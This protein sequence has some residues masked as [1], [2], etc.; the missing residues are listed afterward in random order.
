MKCF[1]NPSRHKHKRCGQVNGMRVE[2]ERNK[3]PSISLIGI[4]IVMIC[5]LAYLFVSNYKPKYEQEPFDSIIYSSERYYESAIAGWHFIDVGSFSIETPSDYRFFF[6]RGVH[7]G[8]VGGFTNST[9]TISFVHGAYYFDACDGI[10]VGEIIGTCDTLKIFKSGT[11]NLIIAQTDLYISAYSK[12]SNEQ[13]DVF[14]AWANTNMNK[15]CLF[16]IYS[17]IKFIE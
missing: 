5:V 6:E 9:D 4:P 3:T 15:D 17:T 8:K 11:R 14:K 16:K 10:V 12:N 7:G 1:E 13:N 2:M